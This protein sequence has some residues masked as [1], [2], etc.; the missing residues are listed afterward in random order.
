MVATG[1]TARTQHPRLCV[2]GA[3]SLARSH[4]IPTAFHI[5]AP[6]AALAGASTSASTHTRRDRCA[7][8]S[9]AA[10]ASSNIDKNTA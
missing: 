9:P 2:E 4:F 10:P 8:T 5:C 3:F 7:R 1:G 6:K